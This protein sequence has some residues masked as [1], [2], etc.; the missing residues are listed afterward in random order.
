MAV[1][2]SF[3]DVIDHDDAENERIRNEQEYIHWGV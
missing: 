1:S 3:R 2:T